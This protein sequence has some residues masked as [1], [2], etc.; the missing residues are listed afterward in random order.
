MCV[1]IQAHSVTDFSAFYRT[2]QVSTDVCYT[3]I[4]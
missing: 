1:A 3:L 4:E 2:D